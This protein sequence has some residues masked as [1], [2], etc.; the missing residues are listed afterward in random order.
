[1]TLLLNPKTG[2]YE[3]DFKGGAHRRL[4]VSLRTP[5]KARAIT[6]HAAVQDFY[7]TADATLMDALRRGAIRVGQIAECVR[8]KRSFETLRPGVAWP[9]LDEARKKYL[10]HLKRDGDET[11]GTYKNAKSALKQLCEFLVVVDEQADARVAL[12]DLRLDEIISKHVEQ[13]MTADRATVTPWSNTLKLTKLGAVYTWYREREPRLAREE[14]RAERVLHSPVL[15]EWLVD[16]PDGRTRFLTREEA[17]RVVA[18]TPDQLRFAVLL[19]LLQGLRIGE[20]VTLRP[21]LDL[22]LD[23]GT[24]SIQEKRV[25][26]KKVWKPKNRESRFLPMAPEL[27]DVARAHLAQFASER[28]VYPGNTNPDA[29]LDRNWLGSHFKRI[30]T[31]AGLVAG[32]DDPTGVTFHTLRHTF[33]SW[34]VMDGVDLKTVATLLGHKTTEE[35]EHTYGHLSRDH[36]L[37]A[38][39]SLGAWYR[40]TSRPT[41]EAKAS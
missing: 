7:N 9:T 15:S 24:I 1:M 13:F 34:L 35:V 21:T 10:E 16:P 33:A 40:T 30:V 25:T 8:A 18:A 37:R 26:P 14:R 39:Q 23:A 12:G 5:V 22:D 4:H 36:K 2:N 11:G 32:Q 19:G 6:L 38:I 20:I 29:P 41:V 31:D 27:V 28:W 17:A 3:G